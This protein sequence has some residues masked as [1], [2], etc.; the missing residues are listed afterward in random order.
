MQ[1]VFDNCNGEIEVISNKSGENIYYKNTLSNSE[2]T[3]TLRHGDKCYVHKNLFDQKKKANSGGVRITGES[4]DV[5]GNLF[6]DIAGNG[7]TRVG[8]S[9][10]NGVK[11]TPL[12]G[13][14]Q[15]KKT[16][17][18]NNVLLNCSNDFAIGVQ[19]KTECTLTPIT[20]E[21]VDNVAFHN[22]ASPVFST[23]SSVLYGD[24]VTYRN[25]VVYATSLGKAPASGVTKKD[26]TTFNLKD[27]DVAQ[28]GATDPVGPQW[29]IV[30][31]E[32]TELQKDVS[33]YYAEL[34]NAMLTSTATPPVPI[35]PAA[36][37]TTPPVPIQP[38]APTTT[39]PTGLNSDTSKLSSIKTEINKL[40]AQISTL[41]ASLQAIKSLF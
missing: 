9:I 4:H 31:P 38:A 25:N 20:T 22:D 36:P 14:Y 6:R 2:G 21:I 40:E 39:P 27:I 10:N 28:F 35:Q 18:R 37:T 16:T 34:L 11:D 15:V 32:T 33:S 26:S 5:N 24:G 13:Y 41:S 1:N 19:V 23:N 12:N 30:E 8:I 17:V 7:T 29:G 3:L